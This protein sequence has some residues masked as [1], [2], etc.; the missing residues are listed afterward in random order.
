MSRL[1]A[2]LL[3]LTALSACASGGAGTT[4]GDGLEATL[5]P[6][7]QVTLSDRS[8]LRYVGV[9]NDSRCPPKVQCIRA[10]DADAHFEFE[11]AGAAAQTL[12]F[13]TERATRLNA[14][15]WTIELTAL[16]QGDAPTATV[17]VGA[18][19]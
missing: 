9:S 15:A 16:S 2:A 19:P 11:A 3:S 7:E 12:V 6:G 4:G 13:N 8:R 5:K 10:G 14:G 17:K 18:A 1:F